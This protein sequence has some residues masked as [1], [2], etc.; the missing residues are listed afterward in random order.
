VVVDR[1]HTSCHRLSFWNVIYGGV[2]HTSLILFLLFLGKRTKLCKMTKLVAV[3]AQFSYRS[4][5]SRR[6]ALSYLGLWHRH[7]EWLL[8]SLRL[9]GILIL[10]LRWPEPCTRS[11]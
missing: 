6:T 4:S 8:I 11:R 2:V 5:S 3:E 10:P 1:K 9:L 7:L